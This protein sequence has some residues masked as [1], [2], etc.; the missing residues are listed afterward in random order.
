MPDPNDI[1]IFQNTFGEIDSY[2][3]LTVATQNHITGNHP[4]V[5]IQRVVQAVTNPVA[6]HKD[7]RKGNCVILVGSSDSQVEGHDL[8]VAIKTGCPDGCFVQTAFPSRKAPRG[9]LVQKV[10]GGDDQT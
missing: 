10:G 4:N 7:L 3:T 8:H 1:V 6:L 2:V 9:Q 5:E